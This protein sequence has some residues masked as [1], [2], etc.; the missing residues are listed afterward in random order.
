M[1]AMTLRQKPCT[2]L[3]RAPLQGTSQTPVTSPCQEI[4][5]RTCWMAMIRAHPMPQIN[6]VGRSTIPC[7]APM[8]AMIL[9]LKT[10]LVAGASIA[11]V[12]SDAPQ[13]RLPH[14]PGAGTPTRSTAPA[15]KRVREVLASRRLI[16][17][18]PRGHGKRPAREVP[19]DGAD[20]TADGPMHRRTVCCAFVGATVVARPRG[21]SS[22]TV[23]AAVPT[24]TGIRSRLLGSTGA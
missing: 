18:D 20:W 7:L 13:S 4:N 2:Q 5:Q 17:P 12:A 24:D 21:V 22:A 8:T 9:P 15:T 10:P 14:G 1:T 23:R 16:A 19:L 11:T 6:A 3:G